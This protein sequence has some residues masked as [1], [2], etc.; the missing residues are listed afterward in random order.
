MTI[1]F[2]GDGSEFE[3]YFE[4]EKLFYKK[5]A[6]S[7]KPQAHNK[8]SSKVKK[9]EENLAEI[10]AILRESLEQIELSNFESLS[11]L[12]AAP[13]GTPTIRQKGKRTTSEPRSDYDSWKPS[14]LTD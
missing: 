4:P 12:M 7:S 1:W 8:K 9:E 11:K 6:K 5:S 3:H 13:E 14:Y 2:W 10:E